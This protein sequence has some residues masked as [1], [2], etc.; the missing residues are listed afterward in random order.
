M[1]TKINWDRVFRET[2]SECQSEDPSVDTFV[3]QVVVRLNQREGLVDT[4]EKL[5]KKCLQALRSNS[6]VRVT[7][8]KVFLRTSVSDPDSDEDVK[9]LTAGSEDKSMKAW[10][11]TKNGEPMKKGIFS[12]DERQLI[13]RAID[14]YVQSVGRSHEEDI[15]WL[16]DR[17]SLKGNKRERNP[18][19]LAWFQIAYQVPNRTPR[20]VF[21]YAYRHFHPSRKGGKWTEKETEELRTLYEEHKADNKF[22]WK[23]IADLMGRHVDEVR[24]KWRA[25]A[26]RVNEG[27]WSE[28]ETAKLK[29]LCL[30][31]IA[32]RKENGTT[33][34]DDSLYLRD[35]CNWLEIANLMGT[36]SATQ[37]LT[38]WYK[39]LAP[40]MKARGE[41]DA[42]QDLEL[43]VSIVESGA[44]EEF[45]V[46]WDKV[47]QDR[48][49]TV[50]RRRW[51]MIVKT[52]VPQWWKK[53]FS[54]HVTALS[55]KFEN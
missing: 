54:D 12:P 26:G 29:E 27:A 6:T 31:N 5:K 35:D 8:K 41:W 42:G 45:E 3:D 33:E 15:G 19:E 34:D 39:S 37:C 32:I 47:V 10:L 50:A 20:Q 14:E 18:A 11:Q 46:E 23:T 1:R 25:I 24:L 51:R 30:K 52:F 44:T 4:A 38:K 36:R 43:L 2:L 17:S 55:A 13:E 49:A 53:S 40:T 22:K 28:E 21:R 16:F 9:L 48:S 7:N